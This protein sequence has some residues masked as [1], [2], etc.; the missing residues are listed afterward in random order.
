VT[1]SAKNLIVKL[2]ALINNARLMIAQDVYLFANSHIVLLTARSQNHYV[3]Q[4][5]RNLIA[6]GNA[7]NQNAQNLSVN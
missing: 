7:I 4:F 1:L 6:I 3:R 5:A 2:C